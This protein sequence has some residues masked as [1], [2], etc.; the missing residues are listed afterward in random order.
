MMRYPILA[1]ALM[2]MPGF[3]HAQPAAEFDGFEFRGGDGDMLWVSDD[4]AGAPRTDGRRLV[5]TAVPEPL[6]SERLPSLVGQ[7]IRSNAFSVTTLLDYSALEEGD[8]A[9]VTLFRSPDSWLSL[10]VERIEPADLIAVRLR[11]GGHSPP[12]GK[13][14][15]A[16]GLAG[17]F[18]ER[19]RLRV[20][21]RD[22]ECM[23]MFA[24][25][26]GFWQVLAETFCPSGI[27]PD[28]DGDR[29][30]ALLGLFATDGAE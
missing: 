22:G 2:V 12:A 23:L 16:T 8:V 11:A 17:S 20:D 21:G 1:A 28:G 9:G 30:T 25:E 27:K 18:G 15:A 4:L 5:L 13:L 3:A 26:R 24:S 7:A 14:V 10:Q 19:V 6:S 29:D